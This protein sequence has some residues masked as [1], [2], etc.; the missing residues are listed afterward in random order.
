MKNKIYTDCKVKI[1]A[2]IFHPTVSDL[3]I[4]NWTGIVISIFEQ[5]KQYYCKIH[6]DKT[7]IQNMPIDYIEHCIKLNLNYAQI[8]VNSNK[9]ITI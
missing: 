7:T 4:E 8:I 9:C 6:L 1:K 2:N 3:L 5:N